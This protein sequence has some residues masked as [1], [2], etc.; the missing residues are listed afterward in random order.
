MKQTK[1]K[2]RY[3]FSVVLTLILTALLAACDGDDETEEPTDTTTTT[4]LETTTTVEVT[5]PTTESAAAPS[6]EAPTMMGDLRD[7]NLTASTTGQDLIDRISE[8]EA[9]CI[10]EAFGETIFQFMLQSPLLT[11]NADPSAA[12]PLF[13]CMTTENV[14]LFSVASLD[15]QAG[16]WAPESRECI[17]T[18]SLEHP[19]AIFI[20]MGLSLE[21]DPESPA[22]T[23]DYNVLIHECLTNEEKKEF[24]LALWLGLDQN[25]PSTGQDIYDLLTESEAQCVAENLSEQQFAAM[26]AAQPLEAVQIGSTVGS[27]CISQETNEKIFTNVTSWAMGGVSEETLS[28]LGDFAKQ[29]PEFVALLAAGLEALQNIPADDFVRITDVGNAQYDCMTEEELLTIQENATTAM[30]TAAEQ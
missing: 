13:N 15:A 16:G 2:F 23:L 18:V 24:T 20:R 3:L 19:Q 1:L 12:G 26:M 7:F 11:Q 6:E 28:C 27:Q 4:V 29:Y 5:T 14:V 10:E 8:E 9:S 30:S 17:T 21:G 22:E 25:S